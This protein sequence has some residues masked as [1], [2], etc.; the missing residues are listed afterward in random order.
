MSLVQPHGWH[1]VERPMGD[2][3]HVMLLQQAHTREDVSLIWSQLSDGLMI[4]AHGITVR[5]VWEPV[6]SSQ[7][8]FSLREAVDVLSANRLQTVA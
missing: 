5:S 1:L 8:A 2:A 7:P 6:L 3:S 4:A